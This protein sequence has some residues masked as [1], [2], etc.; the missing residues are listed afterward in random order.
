[1]G[2]DPRLAFVKTPTWDKADA[3]SREAFEDLAKELGQACTS[4]DLPAHYAGAWEAH[5]AIM[6]TEMAQDLGKLSDQ[7][8]DKVSRS[9]AT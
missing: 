8:G 5:R 2:V 3:D 4:F 9:S 7:A 6:A 1:M